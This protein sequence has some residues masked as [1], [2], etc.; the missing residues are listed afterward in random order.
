MSPDEGPYAREEPFGLAESHVLVVW[1]GL[2]PSLLT[3]ALVASSSCT[4]A[5]GP[6]TDECRLRW[7][8]QGN[9]ESRGQ[10]VAAG[11]DRATV[12]G[13]SGEGGNHC[14]ATFFTRRGEPW[15]T[16]VLWLDAPTPGPQFGRNTTGSRYGTGELGAERPVAANA[17]VRVNGTLSTR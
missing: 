3:I 14:F 2:W 8:A 5:G 7:N 11:F 4:Q 12:Y 16:Y 15:S 1:K 10:V 6:S 9:A 13:W 17:S